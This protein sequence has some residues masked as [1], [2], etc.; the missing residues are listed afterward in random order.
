[1]RVLAELKHLTRDIFVY[2]RDPGPLHDGIWLLLRGAKLLL[3]IWLHFTRSDA[4]ASI[5][6]S[7]LEFQFAARLPTPISPDMP[8]A[9]Q[10][11][12]FEANTLLIRKCLASEV[13]TRPSK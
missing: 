4:S 11:A 3:E 9:A 7:E 1:M 10:I 13:Q 6:Y 2:D 12:S 8:I 5:Y